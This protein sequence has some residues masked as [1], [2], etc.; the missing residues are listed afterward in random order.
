MKQNW[1]SSSDKEGSRKY[2]IPFFFFLWWGKIQYKN[3]LNLI[4]LN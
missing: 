3:E 2:Y 1:E 4:E